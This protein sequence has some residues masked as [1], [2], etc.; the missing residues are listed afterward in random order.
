MNATLLQRELGWLSRQLSISVLSIVLEVVCYGLFVY[1]GNIAPYQ[2][3]DGTE[4]KTV[5]VEM[6]F[7]TKFREETHKG[8]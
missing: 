4:D 1:S 8:G 7:I 6:F 2:V 3:S 5:R